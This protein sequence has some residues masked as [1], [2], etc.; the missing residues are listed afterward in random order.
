MNT[1]NSSEFS[2]QREKSNRS[3]DLEIAILLR[4][5]NE[6]EQFASEL[7]IDAARKEKLAE[8]LRD[9]RQIWSTFL[10][11]VAG[12][13]NQVSL[14]MKTNVSSLGA[15]VISHTHSV[16]RSPSLEKIKTLV[17]VNRSFAQNLK[18]KKIA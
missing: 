5:A 12:N 4:A 14:E 10:S 2:K 16:E 9:N 7:D 15:F 18:G 6:L 1:F 3:H 8:A 13:D 17:S 11:S